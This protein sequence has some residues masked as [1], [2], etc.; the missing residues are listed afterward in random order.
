MA[1]I[2]RGGG[3]LLSDSAEPSEHELRVLTELDLHLF[4]WLYKGT[5]TTD[6]LN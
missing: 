3:V 2:C 5:L 6:P 1:M 4:N